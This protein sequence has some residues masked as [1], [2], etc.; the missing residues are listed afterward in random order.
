MA[1]RDMIPPAMAGAG[2]G[3]RSGFARGMRCAVTLLQ[4][5]VRNRYKEQRPL[6]TAFH[7]AGAGLSG[8]RI[9]GK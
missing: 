2:V 8:S 5:Y 6:F 7:A 1:A 3:W 9:S 4:F